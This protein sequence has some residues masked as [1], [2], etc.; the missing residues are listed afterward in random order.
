MLKLGT[1]KTGDTGS[2]ELRTQKVGNSEWSE[3]ISMDS[4]LGPKAE[5]Q[6]TCEITAM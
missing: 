1:L 5:G 6:E 4:E 2:W 3:P